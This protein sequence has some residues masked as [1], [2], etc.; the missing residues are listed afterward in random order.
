M[1]FSQPK[2][3]PFTTCSKYVCYGCLLVTA[4]TSLHF[5]LQ[6][7]CHPNQP[8]FVPSLVTHQLSQLLS[9]SSYDYTDQID[10][11]V[12]QAHELDS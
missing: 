3:L 10:M 1:S 8:L 6:R 5:I 4:D 11:A 9:Q 7:N 12:W 2:H